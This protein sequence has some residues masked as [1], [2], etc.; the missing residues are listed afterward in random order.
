MN[1]YT[2]LRHELMLA[3]S[4]TR[5][6]HAFIYEIVLVSTIYAIAYFWLLLIPSLMI[7]MVLLVCL[8]FAVVQSGFIAH[9][10]SH[11]SISAVR[12]LN[13]NVGQIFLTLLTGVS[14][15]WFCHIHR[16]HHS[17][18]EDPNQPRTYGG[19]LSL[20]LRINKHLPTKLRAPLLWSISVLR[21]FTMHTDSLHYLYTQP[22]KTRSDQ[23]LMLAHFIIWLILPI[24]I[25]GIPATVFNYVVLNVFTGIYIGPLLLLSHANHP[26]S[27]QTEKHTENH[28]MQH[29]LL[30][31]RNIN[32]SIFSELILKGTREHIE[33]HLFPSIPYANLRQARVITQAFC[34]RHGLQYTDLSLTKALNKI[35]QKTI[36]L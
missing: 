29:N 21:A 25:I 20:V 8:A 28:R 14:Y 33:H 11:S 36:P 5:P 18:P 4:F 2:K 23:I 16:H 22:Q 19:T 15:A 1:L 30:T 12:K 7:N 27:L 34:Q 31:T 26:T 24:A 10:A 13:N 3:S 35:T 32:N 6:K 17:N 9:E